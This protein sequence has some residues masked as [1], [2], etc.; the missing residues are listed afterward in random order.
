MKVEIRKK[1]GLFSAKLVATVETGK[2]KWSLVIETGLDDDIR[3]TCSG[4]GADDFLPTSLEP[5]QVVKEFINFVRKVSSPQ[6]QKS[7]A[8]QVDIDALA[9]QLETT[10][11]PERATLIAEL[12]RR[13]IL[14]VK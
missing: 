4:P 12:D 1:V 13:G 2:G 3:I 5:D 9:E 7:T 6:S 14:K 11:G 8:F 10:A